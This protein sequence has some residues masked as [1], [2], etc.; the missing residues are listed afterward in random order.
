MPCYQSNNVPSGY[1]KIGTGGFATEA[2]CLNACKEG[3]CC[4]GTSCSVKPQCQCDAAAGEVFKGVGTVCS[5]NPC[6]PCGCE[7]TPVSA[8]F[9]ISGYSANS[10]SGLG[11]FRNPIQADEACV[12]QQSGELASLANTITH[13][14]PFVPEVFFG[15]VQGFRCVLSGTTSISDNGYETA[16]INMTLLCTGAATLSGGIVAKYFSLDESFS[17]ECP[18]GTPGYPDYGYV[19]VEYG[20]GQIQFPP[21]CYQNSMTPRDIGTGWSYAGSQIRRCLLPGSAFFCQARLVNDG[22]LALGTMTVTL[23]YT[24]PLP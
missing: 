16:D 8:T 18:L 12:A 19:W 13:T 14:V 17:T 11:G 21:V 23:N 5:P 4:N 6:L 9:S 22:I 2:D 24:N 20:G 3:A 15:G 7:N 10:F 1:G